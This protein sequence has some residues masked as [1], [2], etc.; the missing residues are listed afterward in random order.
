M[1]KMGKP[2]VAAAIVDVS[3]PNGEGHT[4]CADM[5]QAHK[6]LPVMMISDGYSEADALQS[7]RAGAIDYFHRPHHREEL[8]ARLR[9]HLRSKSTSLDV[10]L[11]IGPFSFHPG[12]R[13]LLDER[14]QSRI[15][16]TAKE[17]RILRYLHMANGRAVPKA[18]LLGVAWG[19]PDTSVHTL[20]TH[21]Y[22]LRTKL[23]T[24]GAGRPLLVT[25]AGG[26]VLDM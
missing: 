15:W 18:E 26:Y 14:R 13:I 6:N 9:A 19:S 2:G 22:R 7:L 25:T 11:K 1:L 23:K 3:L 17:A 24:G 10:H 4:L 8:L 20:Q 5:A 21:I 12:Q 16:L